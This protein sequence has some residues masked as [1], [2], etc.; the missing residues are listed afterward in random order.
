MVYSHRWLRPF[1]MGVLKPY[2]TIGEGVV[3]DD[4]EE[5]VDEWFE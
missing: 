1:A 2:W 3:E 4:V 5:R